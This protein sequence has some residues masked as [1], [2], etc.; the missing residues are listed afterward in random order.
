[1]NK[2][3]MMHLFSYGC[4]GYNPE[5][6]N[7]SE[8]EKKLLDYIDECL[9]ETDKKFS[10]ACTRIMLLLLEVL[11]KMNTDE[12]LTDEEIFL[13]EEKIL[14]GFRKEDKDRLELFLYACI[15]TM[16]IYN[17]ERQDEKSLIMKHEVKNNRK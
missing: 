13:R 2:L 10:E 4:Y 12:E 9:S 8:E 7:L 15:Q 6:E 16:G 1:M 11:S 3:F 17:K 5:Y 14:T